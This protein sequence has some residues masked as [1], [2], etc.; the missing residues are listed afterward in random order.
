VEVRGAEVEIGQDRPAARLREATPSGCHHGLADTALAARD[1]Y[2]A[3]LE[4]FHSLY[5]AWT[6]L[7]GRR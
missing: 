3:Q 1:G 7:G 6:L 4:A 2:D 5:V